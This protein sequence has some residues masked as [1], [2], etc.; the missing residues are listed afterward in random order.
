MSTIRFEC[1]CFFSHSMFGDRRMMAFYLCPLH[2]AHPKVQE[3]AVKDLCKVIR[4]LLE[5]EPLEEI[6]AGTSGGP[7][8]TWS[9]PDE[10]VEMVPCQA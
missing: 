8:G 4:Q 10:G 9:V 7:R 5:D 6:D 2:I 3:T 1:G